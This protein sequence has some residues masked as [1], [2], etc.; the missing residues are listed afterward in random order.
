M[1]KYIKTLSKDE[2]KAFIDET[3][4]EGFYLC[5]P[6]FWDNIGFDQL[7]ALYDKWQFEPYECTI[8]GKLIQHKLIFGKEYILKLILA[9]FIRNDNRLFY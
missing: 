5:Q 3:E 6:P 9:S 4:R 1:R 2:L 8:N 7:S